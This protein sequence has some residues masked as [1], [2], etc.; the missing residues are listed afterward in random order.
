MTYLQMRSSEL[1]LRIGLGGGHIMINGAVRAP[2]FWGLAMT[3]GVLRITLLSS[4]R[5]VRDVSMTTES[6]P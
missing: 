4:T 2:L 3:T 5:E 1:S 6:M